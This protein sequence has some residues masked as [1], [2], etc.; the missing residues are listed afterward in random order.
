MTFYMECQFIKKFKFET[1]PGSLHNSEM[2]NDREAKFRAPEVVFSPFC[3]L[4]RRCCSISL[5]FIRYTS[6]ITSI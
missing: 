3:A 5:T 6:Y 1:P 2:A 4:S